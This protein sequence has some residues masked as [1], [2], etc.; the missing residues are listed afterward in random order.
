MNFTFENVFFYVNFRIFFFLIFNG[1]TRI[2]HVSKFAFK[3]LLYIQNFERKLFSHIV[4]Y[5]I[6][7]FNIM[8]FD[9]YTLWVRIYRSYKQGT[10]FCAN[11]DFHL[12][13][14]AYFIC[15]VDHTVN[16]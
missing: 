11:P 2:H 13:T 4:I 1:I 8:L 6:Q 3:I 10:Y 7:Y 12:W 14:M 16:V 9:L 5:G 15:I